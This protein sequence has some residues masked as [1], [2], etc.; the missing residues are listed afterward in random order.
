MPQGRFD[1]EIGK[2]HLAVGG[3]FSAIL[4]L[5]Y[6]NMDGRDQNGEAQVQ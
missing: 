5:S 1:P 6:Q 4:L 3:T 2:R